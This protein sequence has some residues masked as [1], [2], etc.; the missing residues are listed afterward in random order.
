MTPSFAKAVRDAAQEGGFVPP[1]L[2]IAALAQEAHPLTALADHDRS[3]ALF[4]AFHKDFPCVGFHLWHGRELSDQDIAQLSGL[5]RWLIHSFGQWTDKA[6]PERRLFAALLVTLKA[7]RADHEFWRTISDDLIPMSELLDA[8]AKLISLSQFSFT[9][10]GFGPLPIWEGEAVERFMQADREADWVEISESW[11]RFAETISPNFFYGQAIQCLACLSFDRL[12][13]VSNSVTQTMKAMIIADSLDQGTR[14]RLGLESD[15]PFIEFACVYSE[16]SSIWRRVPPVPSQPELLARIFAKVAADPIRWAAWMRAF[17][18]WPIRFPFLH[19]PLGE[20][21]AVVSYEA[22]EAY[23]SSVD[24]YP[25]R[26]PNTDAR[27]RVTDCLRTFREKASPERRQELWRLA[28]DRWKEWDFHSLGGYLGQIAWSVLDYAIVGYAI[29]C[30][31]PKMPRELCE[32]Y[33]RFLNDVERAWHPDKTAANT[34]WN[35]VLSAFQPFAHA[36]SVQEPEGDWLNLGQLY[37]P[38]EPRDNRYY[39]EMFDSNNSDHCFF[40]R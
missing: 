37:W 26:T 5:I 25:E 21:L 6:D 36:V 1:S 27:L 30:I 4:D 28:Y 20:A 19:G 15:S 31:P 2:L 18:R 14:L 22:V 9:T 3:N 13:K 12:V 23:V 17:N 24:L 29:E 32:E 16:T 11:H 39:L 33:Q 7:I 8:F 10:R 40:E 34:R 35:A 38:F